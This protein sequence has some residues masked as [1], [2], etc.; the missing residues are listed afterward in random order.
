MSGGEVDVSFR[1]AAERNAVKGVGLNLNPEPKT[2]IRLITLAA[3]AALIALPANAEDSIRI[4]THGKTPDQVKAEV[5][6][7]A[8][9]LCARE[10]AVATFQYYEMRA[11]VAGTVRK[12][13][14][15]E[16]FQVLQLAQ[17]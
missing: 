16:G 11:C 10:T 9:T 17:K 13:L 4:S 8:E 2:M 5:Y 12:T 3:A 15:Q 1:P 6:K 7:A 14:A